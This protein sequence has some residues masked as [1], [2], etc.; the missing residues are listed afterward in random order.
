M[1]G[2]LSDICKTRSIGVSAWA[3]GV[4]IAHY[5]YSYDKKWKM[6][7]A[8]LF[9]SIICEYVCGWSSFLMLKSV[10]EAR[11]VR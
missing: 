8:S 3:E 6:T 1:D 4:R 7:G 11:C 10:S 2:I 9:Y 5:W